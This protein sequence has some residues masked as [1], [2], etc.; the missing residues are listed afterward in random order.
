MR[1]AVSG[2]SPGIGTVTGRR[3]TALAAWLLL[4]CTLRADPPP[5]PASPAASAPA[6]PVAAAPERPG[7]PLPQVTIEAQRADLGH[8]LSAYV[9]NITRTTA[10]DEALQRWRAPLCPLVAGLGRDKAEFI[11]QRLSQIAKAASAPLDAENCQANL[12][13]IVTSTPEVLLKAW[14]EHRSAFAGVH[15]TPAAFSRFRN[16]PRPIRVWYNRDFGSPDDSPI[17]PGSMRM[18]NGLSNLPSSSGNF[19]GSKMLVKNLL[20]FTSVAVIVDARQIVGLEIGQLADYIAMISLT[21]TDLDAPLGNAPTIL[22][23][24]DARAAGTPLPTGLSSWD[25]SFLRALY[26]TSL[27]RITQRSVIADKMMLDLAP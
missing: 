14:G 21:E 17:L 11:L 27:S 3:C 1:Y 10:R 24:F 20:V 9:A 23:L 6:A 12:A 4:A 26:N 5:P 8:R 15:G 7:K 13:I 25:Q 19:T 18:G 22:R 2:V 16:K